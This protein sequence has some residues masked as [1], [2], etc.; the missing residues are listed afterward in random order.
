M[1]RHGLR[2]LITNRTLATR[3]GTE[4]YVRDLAIGLAERGHSPIVYT[5]L[6][7]EVAQE[8]R[9]R[10]VP[11]T[12]DLLSI[13]E[14]PDVIHGHH[15]LET[16]AA[17]LAFPDAPAVTVCHSWIGWADAPLDF[18]RVLRYVAVD[19]T[20]RDRLR[21]EHGIP[22][23]RIQVILNSV[24][25][26][27]FRPRAPLP[28]RPKRALVFS[29]AAGPGRS[30]LPAIRRACAAAGIE[31][32]VVGASAGRSLARPEE[33]LEEF[34]LVFAK[35]RAA[36]EAMAV[37]AAV[38]LCDMT[39][40][41]PMVTTANLDR[42]RQLNFGMR[43][44]QQPVTA[45]FLAQEI[46]RY[47]AADA[48]AVSRAVRANAGTDL[49]IE[50]LCSLYGA[51]VAEHAGGGAGDRLAEQRAATAYLQELAPRLLQRDI[52]ASAFQGLVRK[53]LL[54]RLTRVAAASSGRPWLAQLLRL[55]GL[56]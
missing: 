41:G 47:D 45:E 42:L 52:L 5:P 1:S 16:L 14:P 24:D 54:G 25:L 35:A 22:D 56:D 39:G 13:A 36:L 2:V 37:G 43:A 6:P 23:E 51:V 50:E 55:E 29:N 18:P 4:V 19:H 20:C 32:E 9:S 3:T 8:I 44:L 15:G 34:D 26:T 48:A 11:V 46:A 53:P 49:M 17:L 27:R 30:H 7:G 40:A 10:T 31:V 33:A 21:F 12:D 28:A 38:I